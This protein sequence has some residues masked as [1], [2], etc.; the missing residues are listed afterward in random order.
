MKSIWRLFALVPNIRSR[1]IKV[2]LAN[3]VLGLAGLVQPLIYGNIL[4]VLIQSV[5][6]IQPDSPKKLA[7]ALSI[8]LL[9]EIF[10]SVSETGAERLS[11]LLF[12]DV[13]TDIRKRLFA[14]LST[15]SIEYYEKTRAGEILERVNGGVA[16][17]ARWI[18]GLSE[19]LLG[20]L[21]MIVLVLGFLWI[22]L[23][24]VG[25]IMTLSLPLNFYW[26]I[27]KVI[28]TRPIRRERHTHSEKAT[29]EV[30]ETISHIS[31][32]RSFAQET[33]R[34]NRF[35]VE[36]DKART[37]AL[38]Q[39]RIEWQTNFSRSLLAG[40]TEVVALGIVVFGV[41][42][43]RNTP[44]EILLVSLYLQRLQVSISPLS[45]LIINTGD[46]ETSA[47][48]IVEILDVQP[49]VVD[50]PDARALTTIHRIEFN[51]VSFH[52]PGKE[53]LVLDKIS[54]QL[55]KGQTLALVGPSGVGKTTITKLL[56]RFYEPTSGQILI[57][58]E[59]IERFT[60]HSI[61]S[62]MGMVMQDVVLFNDTVEENLRFSRPKATQKEIK[63]AAVRAHADIFVKKLP[64]GYNTLVGERGI[65]LSGGEK[66]RIAVARAILRNPQL[67]I[68]DEATSALD[69]QSERFVQDGL[70]QLMKDRTAVIIA[71]RLSTVRKADQ[72]LVLEHG[73]VLEQGTHQELVSHKGLYARLLSLQGGLRG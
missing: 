22:K 68:L 1:L 51:N 59:L 33:H 34:L 73:R 8:L 16:D 41:F 63:E 50:L 69:S 56:L 17:F 72:I 37:A 28:R 61:R 27:S 15:L 18:L 6:G 26:A 24:L 64:E 3:S 4:N 11:D 7:I 67:I 52:Y 5:H 46:V 70:A 42:H 43:G 29:G 54:F 13:N 9:L 32:V 60:Q 19:G 14:H 10:A 62:A 25:F 2:V 38:Q 71:H 30:S 45:R 21:I 57:N 44:G 36:I 31:T 20:R 40:V 48:R 47:E 12:L 39:S 66:Q 58:G 49:T 35:S 53:Q 23:P 65:K 55:P